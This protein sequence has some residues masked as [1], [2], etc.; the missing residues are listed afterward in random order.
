MM[1]VE[2]QVNDK[3]V[4]QWLLKHGA[5]VNLSNDQSRSALYEAAQ[6][7]KNPTF[8][9]QLIDAGANIHQRER[10]YGSTPLIIACRNNNAAV[11]SLLIAEGA[12]VN[13]LTSKAPYITPLQLAA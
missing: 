4:T 10:D 9:K 6:H 3:G 13:S 8:T 2:H 7:N 5:D 1:A 12:R 11:V